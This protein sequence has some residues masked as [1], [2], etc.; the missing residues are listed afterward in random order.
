MVLYTQSGAVYPDVSW[1]EPGVY[2]E[3]NF[4][5][6]PNKSDIVL[7]LGSNASDPSDKIYIDVVPVTGLIRKMEYYHRDAATGVLP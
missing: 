4:T 5:R 1:S 2:N 6:A 3:G 7:R